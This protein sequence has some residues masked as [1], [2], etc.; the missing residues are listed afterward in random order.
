[1]DNLTTQLAGL[2]SAVY[3]SDIKQIRKLL[4]A[5]VSPQQQ[6]A[7]G[8]SPLMMATHLGNADI[9]RMLQAAI[10]PQPQST[11]SFFNDQAP[12]TTTMPVITQAAEVTHLT[13]GTVSLF[14]T[15]QFV[16]V[17]KAM[18]ILPALLQ[19]PALLQLPAL[20][21]PLAS[22]QLLA[23]EATATTS[24]KS[25]R[26]RKTK[27]KTYPIQETPDTVALKEAVCNGDIQT[28][29]ALLKAKVSFRPANWYDTPLLVL[30]A[31]R[32]HS[33]I[34][35]ALLDAGADPNKGY[36][37]LPLHLASENGH[38][39]TVQRLINSG[40]QIQ[41][42]EEGGQTALMR[43]AAGGHLPIVQVLVDR[44]ANVNAICQGETALMFA[45]RNGHRQVYEFLYPYVHARGT[46][47]EEQALQ[48][49]AIL[50][51]ESAHFQNELSALFDGNN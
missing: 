8:I 34:V 37:R 20:S 48:Q 5:G 6:D 25:S 29:R 15:V 16:P 23:S 33:E 28:V 19:P 17:V 2:F 38:L 42:E 18:P 30:A 1:M 50:T 7:D 24:K 4:D 49:R 14:P 51:A 27:L 9:I 46:L 44:G 12:I 26:R 21:R 32:G 35:Q 40:A 43:A 11:H 13:I 22:L 10:A 45:S 47:V 3:H 41:T 36:A 31:G 39:E